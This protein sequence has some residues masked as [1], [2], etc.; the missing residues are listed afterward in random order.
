MARSEDLQALRECIKRLEGPA[1]ADRPPSLA[2]G[3]PAIDNHLPDEGLRAPGIHEFFGDECD[4]S[5]FGLVAALAGRWSCIDRDG[6]ETTAGSRLEDDAPVF[7]LRGPA[8]TWLIDAQALWQFGISPQRVL[9]S[10]CGREADGL[11]A[12]E[13]A[14]RCSVFPILVGEGLALT[15]LQ[16][17]RIQLAAE[18]GRATVLLLPPPLSQPPP[19]AA[20]RWRV[21][22][23]PVHRGDA[24]IGSPRWLIELLRCRGGGPATWA[25]EWDD[26]QRRLDLV[27]DVAG[28][29]LA[30]TPC[31][32]LA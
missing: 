19:A 6:M 3:V 32:W 12:L 8:A 30:A 4:A 9:V 27:A 16:A 23:L 10:Q 7:W 31:S 26:E 22:S 29:P 28:R 20:T 24:S 11:W 17:R 14:S 5:R 18:A 15:P 1:S 13:E 25:L 21:S 2:F